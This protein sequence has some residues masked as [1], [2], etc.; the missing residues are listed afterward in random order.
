MDHHTP[1]RP[2]TNPGR[3]P[4][5]YSN[6]R[7]GWAASNPS[8]AGRA[9]AQQVQLAWPVAASAGASAPGGPMITAVALDSC[10][11]TARAVSGHLRLPGRRGR[12]R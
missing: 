2:F 12:R 8:G 9:V 11:L 7:V 4:I 5:R 10:T 6:R 1:G 3:R